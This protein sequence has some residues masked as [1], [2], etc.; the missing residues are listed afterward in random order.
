MGSGVYVMA[1]ETPSGARDVDAALGPFETIRARQLIEG[2]L[3]AVAA[4]C[5][6]AAALQG[7]EETV[8][9]MEDE[10]LHGTPPVRGDR[11]FHARV[12]EASRNS[13][14]V[15]VVTELFDERSNP[16]FERLGSHYEGEHSWVAA[17]AEHRAVIEAIAARDA[18]RAREAM[19]AHLERS[20]DRFAADH[21]ADAEPTVAAGPHPK[22]S[23]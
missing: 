19:R 3:A 14:L 6:D 5:I 16:L 4:R 11:L 21:A 23:T 17:V 13:A 1:R 20:H 15:R 8:R 2:E 12:A 7:L 18:R 9:A 22:E 10:I